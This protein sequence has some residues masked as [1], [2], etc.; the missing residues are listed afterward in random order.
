MISMTAPRKYL[1]LIFTIVLVFTNTVNLANAQGPTNFANCRLGVGGVKNNVVGYN[2]GQLNMGRYLDWGAK[3]PR[4]AGLAA[5]IEYFQMVRVHQAKADYGS[6]WYGPPRVYLNPPSYR[7]KPS[8]SNIANIAQSQPG[9]LWLIGNEIERVDWSNGNGTY[10]GQDEITPELY[11]TAFHDIRNIIKTA[12]PTAR[13]GIGAV[14]QATPLRLAYLDRVWNSYSSQYGYS[15]GQDIDVWN[16]HGFVIREVLNDWGA[17]IP[18]GFNNNDSDPTN[19]YNP[20]D[21]L[22]A[23][24]SFQTVLN[25]HH[26]L[27]Y[28]RQFIEAFRAWMAAHGERNKPLIN[29][30]YGILMD[31]D[32]TSVINF[33]NATFDYMFSATN[34][35]IGYPV[36]ENRL[37]QGWVWYSLNDNSSF[38]KGTLFD[39]NKSLTSVGNAWKSYVSNSGKPLASQPRRNLLVTNL[40]SDPAQA[41]VF[42][43]QTKTVTLKVDVANS[44]NTSTATGN[45]IVVKF[46]DGVPNAPGSHQIGSSQIL[47]DL[48]GCGGFRTIQVN[49]SGRGVGNHTWY[50][51]VESIANETNTGDNTAQSAFSILAIAPN[52][53][54]HLPLILK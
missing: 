45:N 29:T 16:V 9:M 46:W 22:L 24:A 3:N 38:Q 41:L 13:I 8:L 14:I 31:L 26:D 4:P 10:G 39:A 47:N 23:N 44:G 1:Y 2:M 19:N 18:A 6:S 36:D 54:I 11:A 32:N 25:A 7:V 20:A 15:M 28:Y 51:K 49:W 53:V 50:V 48:P 42:P 5:D 35:S 12:D 33:L 34:A 17:D 21:A 30:E 40:S 27:N 52:G 43:G 37:L